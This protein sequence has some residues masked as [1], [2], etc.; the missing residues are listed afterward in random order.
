[1]T[2]ART[3]GIT[4]NTSV[5]PEF[6][7]CINLISSWAGRVICQ[8]ALLIPV[9]NT[10]HPRSPSL[11]A[12]G[13]GEGWGL[14]RVTPNPPTPPAPIWGAARAGAGKS[15]ALAES[16]AAFRRWRG[17][18]LRAPPPIMLGGSFYFWTPLALLEGARSTSKASWG[19]AGGIPSPC[20]GTL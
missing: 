9:I 17:G 19:V 3:R 6:A 10:H 7:P 12:H 20:P 1:M 13:W 14:R 4:I 8:A 2:F 5:F 11:A 18:T 15:P 16:P